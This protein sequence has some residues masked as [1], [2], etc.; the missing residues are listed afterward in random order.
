MSKDK[1]DSKR[2]RPAMGRQVNV[3]IPDA[4][5]VDLEAISAGMGLDISDVIRMILTENKREYLDRL[6]TKK[7]PKGK[8]K[9]GGH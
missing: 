3:R 6:E 1:D 8:A 5:M 9:D 2:G 4:L 7:K